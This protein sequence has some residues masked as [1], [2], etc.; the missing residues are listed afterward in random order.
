MLK[1]NIIFL[2]VPNLTR[3]CHRARTTDRPTDRQTDRQRGGLSILSH[4]NTLGE[5]EAGR[6]AHR[7][8]EYNNGVGECLFDVNN[9]VFNV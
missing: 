8:R 6:G 2:A 3:Q 4:Q 1:L 5:E 9:I 7:V